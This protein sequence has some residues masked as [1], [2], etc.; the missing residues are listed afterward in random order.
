[1]DKLL[2]D[3]PLFVEVARRK[4][5]SHAA[6]MLDMPVSTV[7]RRIAA[8]ER[9]LG[10]PLFLRNSRNVELTESGLDF[11]NRC[12]FILNEAELARE[13]VVQKVQGTAGKVR[14]AMRPDSY[15]THMA[16][17]LLSFARKWPDVN[18]EVYL[19]DR[20]VDLL[21]EP[22]D[23]EIRV[24]PLPDSSLK[25]RK[26]ARVYPDLYASP[27]FLEKYSTP[28]HPQ[29][30]SRVPCVVFADASLVTPRNSHIWLF[31]K[32][33]QTEEVRVKQAHLVNHLSV[34]TDFVLAGLGV[35]W[36]ARPMVEYH[37][38]RGELVQLLPDWTLEEG[39]DISIV[40]ASSELPRRV[41]LLVEHL[42]E[43]SREMPHLP[44]IEPS[45]R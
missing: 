40:M 43:L 33:G 3:L 7:S 2:K 8:L 32:D 20:R 31:R 30:L 23:L 1:M 14:I 15:H 17:A 29:D 19:S 22:F 24:G 45:N 35:G 4:S 39:V 27:E 12:E 34:A 16:E 37:R 44:G 11:Y 9:E 21:T 26:L 41:R 18:L 28:V 38:K 25:V 36:L 10:L 42:V 6:E 5:F 13:Q